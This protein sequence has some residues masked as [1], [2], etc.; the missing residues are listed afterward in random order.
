MLTLSEGV[1]R[2]FVDEPRTRTVGIYQVQGQPFGMILGYKQKVDPATGLKVYNDEGSP[3]R[4]D[5]Y[6][7]LGNG[8]AKM[9]GGIEQLNFLET[10]QIRC[11]Y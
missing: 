6:E 3:M 9:T 8:I 10:I 1:T 2:L 4:T 5:V 11:S 7:I